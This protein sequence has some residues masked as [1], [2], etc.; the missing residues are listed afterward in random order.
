MHP[1]D[2][3]TVLIRYG[4]IGVKSSR[5]QS[6][7]EAQLR[8][9]IAAVLEDRGLNASVERQ[10]TRLYAH[11]TRDT[12]ARVAEATSDVPGVVSTSA[13]VRTEPT[14]DAICEALVSTARALYDGGS[15]AVRGR[16][17]GADDA[18]PFASTDIEQQGGAAVGKALEESGHA[19]AVDLEEPT[20]ALSVE[21][22]PDDAYIFT[23]KVDGPGGL[24]VGTQEPVVALVSGGI[25]SPV[26]AWEMLKRGCPVVPLYVDLGEYGGVDHRARAERTVA[27]LQRYAPRED[28]RLCVVPGDEGINR[29]VETVE[30]YRMLAIRRYM[31]RIGTLL[32]DDTDAVG[33]VSGEAI[34]QKS[35]QT[36]A[37]LRVSSA[38]SEYPIHRPLVNVDKNTITERAKRIGTYEDATIDAGCYRLAP[39]SPATKAPLAEVREAEPEDIQEY[40]R[41]AV[42]QVDVVGSGRP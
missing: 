9:N 10:H 20:L 40:A 11:T 14:L 6:R 37:N 25:D 41:A 38:V 17:A 1:P 23:E 12:V 18:H 16:R 21:C 35:S 31:Y 30:Q 29:I 15:F 3:D 28:M 26:A 7:M 4:E 33:L 36:S 5:V 42:E 13:A 39:D 8:D 22:R 34:G 32:A 27:H 2:A 24:P 19:P